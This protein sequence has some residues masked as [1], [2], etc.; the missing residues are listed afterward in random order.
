MPK[1]R[2]LVLD[3][4]TSP[5]VSYHWRTRDE[6]IGME[7]I[8][9]DTTILCFAA[10]WLG[11]KRVH[12]FGTGGR[13]AAKVR[14]DR[15]VMRRLWW[16]LDKAD[17]VIGHNIKQFDLKRIRSRMLELGMKPYSPVRPVDTL[18][19]SFRNFGHT[20][21]KL[22]WVT[23]KQKLKKSEHPEFPGISLWVAVLKDMRKAWRV[24][25]DYNIRDVTANAQYYLDIRPWIEGHPNVG[26]YKTDSDKPTCP[27]CGGEEMNSWG[28]ISAQMNRYHRYMCRS[29]GGYARGRMPVRDMNKGR[30]LAN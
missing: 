4:E 3:I 25:R 26:I 15:A 13:G 8:K 16:F 27:R 19:E 12:W 21:N 11:E 1:P 2:I 17:V 30:L 18:S 28:Y 22:A 5:L 24:M 14:D 6:N 20:F 29:C 9:E 10:Q 7:Q 23:R